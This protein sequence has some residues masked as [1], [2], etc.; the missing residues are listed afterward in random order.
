[1][2]TQKGNKQP[3][4]VDRANHRPTKIIG[5]TSIIINIIL[6][7]FYLFY[8]WNKYERN[9]T[10]DAITL[11]KSLATLLQSENIAQ[12][13]GELIDLEKSNYI[14]IKRNLTQL[15][16]TTL[17]I[18]FAY[19][20]G[21]RDEKLVFLIDS[22]LPDS[23]N[24]SYPGQTYTDSDDVVKTFSTKESTTTGPTTDR[25]GTWYSALIPIFDTKNNEVVAVFELDFPARE[26]QL[27]LWNQM[28]PD[29][30]ITV[31][32]ILFIIALYRAAYHYFNLKLL[33]DKTAINEAL[34]HSVFDQAPVGIALVNDKRFV[35]KS[36]FGNVNMN[37]KFEEILGRS[38][39]ELSDIQW[40]DIT[41]PEDLQKDLTKFAQ[42]KTGKINVYSTTKRFLRPDGSYI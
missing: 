22:E 32:F 4:P 19:L 24:Y 2:I 7:F 21:I 11:T 35:S 36:Q 18:R 5:I 38:S 33:S 10:N 14:L 29:M 41:H 17:D 12:I 1:M 15:V 9:A 23:S 37:P 27:N 30:I 42:F 3:R 40:S 20:M 31:L 28:I 34:Y 6:S 26:W 39:Q 25:W 8:S 13:S 16:Q